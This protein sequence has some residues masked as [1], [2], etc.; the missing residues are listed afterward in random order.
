MLSVRTVGEN[1]RIDLWDASEFSFWHHLILR[2]KQLGSLWCVLTLGAST[3]LFILYWSDTWEI[4]KGM[5]HNTV[6][7]FWSKFSNA[8]N[9]Q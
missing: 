7:I 3:G 9:L 6:S 8:T 2:L 4:G 1:L 5:E